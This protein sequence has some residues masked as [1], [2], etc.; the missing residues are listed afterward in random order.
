MPNLLDFGN[1]W[2]S[3]KEIDLRPIRAEAERMT[4][5]AL[6]GDDEESKAGF[7]QVLCEEPARAL[8]ETDASRL[9]PEPL[10]V[11]LG[12]AARDLTADL[13]V[14]LLG[15]DVE[16]P[17]RARELF[18]EWRA[19]GKKIIVVYNPSAQIEYSPWP[20]ASV[21]RGSPKDRAFLEN[22]FV[23]AVL[24]LLP[25]RLLSLAR[26]YPLFR[27]RVARQLITD[28]SM[29]N[30]SYSLT[31]GIAEVV[32]I[33]DV[34]FNVADMIVLTKAQAMMA[35]K[36][37]LALGL[38]GRWQDHLTAFGGTVGTGFL[39]RQL[40]RELVG[41]IPVWGILPKVAVAYAGTYVLG[42]GILQWYTTGRQV[43][44]E[45]MRKFYRDAFEQ[46]KAIARGLLERMPRPK[47]RARLALPR[48]DRLRLPG[49]TRIV[50]PNCGATN[51]AGTKF[52]GSCGSA[53]K[54]PS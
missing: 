41:L 47:R 27:I 11:N 17:G 4:W 23:P 36:L 40:A 48:P 42:E 32:P 22:E 53:L 44:P 51:P 9:G 18:Q 21:L 46:G 19:A 3:L 13:I 31:T 20:G 14:L 16:N 1:I 34:P 39:W 8:P 29:A 45:S 12:E 25:D 43:T 10:V 15:A 26:Y 24:Y 54:V 7:R 37:G 38:P 30:A 35:Y 49:R 6:V 52:C 28:T 2:K 5:I 33:L 50:C